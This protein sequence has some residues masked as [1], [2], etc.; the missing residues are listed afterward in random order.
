MKITTSLLAPPTQLK[1]IPSHSQFDFA[2]NSFQCNFDFFF[3]LSSY[4]MKSN[5]VGMEAS[6]EQLLGKACAKFLIFPCLNMSFELHICKC[7]CPSVITITKCTNSLQ[8]TSVQSRSDGVNT[9]LFEKREHIEKLH[10][11]HNLLRKIQVFKN[12][13]SCTIHIYILITSCLQ[14]TF[15][16][17]FN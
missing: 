8:I 7:R 6:M 5:I 4:R 1:G 2:N 9:S 3:L 15:E 12:I 17:I 13:V 16:K 11:T 10:R 14:G